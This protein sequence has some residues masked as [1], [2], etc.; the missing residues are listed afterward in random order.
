MIT[1]L[2]H[3]WK[4]TPAAEISWIALGLVAQLLFSMRFLI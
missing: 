2:A 3:W 1:S 4:A